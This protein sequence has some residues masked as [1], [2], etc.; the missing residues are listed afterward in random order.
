MAKSHEKDVRVVTMADGGILILQ[1]PSVLDQKKR[2]AAK[3][4]ERKRAQDSEK[5]QSRDPDA[6]AVS[7]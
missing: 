3:R 2:E 6:V 1:R 4:F 7:R 5:R